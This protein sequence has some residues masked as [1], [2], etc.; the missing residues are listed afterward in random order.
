MSEPK[1]VRRWY[2]ECDIGYGCEMEHEEG[3]FVF[4]TDYKM[5]ESEND[6]LKANV[7]RLTKAGDAMADGYQNGDWNERMI[8]NRI[9]A[10]NAAKGVQS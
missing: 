10:W 6:R 9:S 4:Y 1:K 7:E 5:L 8:F 2:Y 3:D